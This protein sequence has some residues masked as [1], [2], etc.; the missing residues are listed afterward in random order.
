MKF[1]KIKP[2]QE[3]LNKGFCGPAVLKMVLRFY[4]IE[5]SE[6]ELAKLAGVAKVEA[7]MARH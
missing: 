5:K 2:F 1:I 6:R 7:P 4:G 3:T